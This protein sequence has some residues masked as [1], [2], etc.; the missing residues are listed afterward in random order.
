[1]TKGDAQREQ[2]KSR[3]TSRTD[4]R[5]LWRFKEVVL[6]AKLWRGIQLIQLREWAELHQ[7]HVQGSRGEVI[8][9]SHGEGSRAEGM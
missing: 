2:K 5:D 9:R 3:D 6:S 7:G 4:T 8:F 1:M